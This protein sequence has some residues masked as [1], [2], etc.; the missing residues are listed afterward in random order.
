[1]KPITELPLILKQAQQQ[2][3]CWST[4]LV[5]PEGS[6]IQGLGSLPSIRLIEGFSEGFYQQLEVNQDIAKI[7]E[8]G[9]IL[10]IICV[11]GMVMISKIGNIGR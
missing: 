3:L 4:P 6:V 5:Y 7:P 10:P 8:S 1:M 9:G 11:L 2:C